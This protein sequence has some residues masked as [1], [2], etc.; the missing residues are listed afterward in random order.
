M[1]FSSNS[2]C[3]TFLTSGTALA[4]AAIF[5]QG[6][7]KDYHCMQY[8]DKASCQKDDECAFYFAGNSTVCY[9]KAWAH[10]DSDPNMDISQQ[11]VLCDAN[12]F[13]AWDGNTCKI[14]SDIGDQGH[15]GASDNGDKV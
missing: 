3:S 15:N 5:V 12:S 7:S 14:A 10:C 11:K 4:G 1:A 6:C 13:C 8:K 9:E 2:K